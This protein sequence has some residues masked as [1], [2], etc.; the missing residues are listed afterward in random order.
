MIAISYRREDSTPVAGRL[1]DRL[2]AEFGKEN[3]FMDFDSIPYGVDFR[4]HI[5]RTL[6]RADVVVAVIG[7]GW[8]GGQQEAARRI[9]DPSDF[10]RLEIAGALQR[11][12]PVIPILVDDTPM[13]KADAL[14]PEIAAFAF[15]NA[16]VL[17]TGIDFHHHADRLVAGIRDLLKDIPVAPPVKPDTSE[18][19]GP[20]EAPP[21]T[22]SPEAERDLAEKTKW[23]GVLGKLKFPSPTAKPEEHETPTQKAER[24]AVESETAAPRKSS[25]EEPAMKPKRASRPR[26]QGAT[27]AALVQRQKRSSASS[28]TASAATDGAKERK[29]VLNGKLIGLFAGG[30]VVVVAMYLVASSVFSP[31]KRSTSNVAETT[32]QPS[33]TIAPQPSITPAPVVAATAAPSATPAEN[34]VVPNTPAPAL[35]PIAS[36]A[37]EPIYQGATPFASQVQDEEN[38]RQLIREY[39]A[40]LSRHDLDAVVSKFGDNVDY[41]GQG[42]HDKR[43]IRID[44]GNYLRRWDRIAFEPG[45]IHVTR[46]PEGDFVATFNFPFAVGQGRAPDK[47]GIS[48]SV[49]VLRKDLQGNVQIVSQ[50]EK[51]LAGRSK[52]RQSRY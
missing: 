39:Y 37:T 1:H 19:V 32:P 33:A 44:T 41:Q 45:D 29:F 36:A 16:L 24:P 14:P 9:D 26:K 15:R 6:E 7:P 47:R 5:K 21:K 2:R 22:P 10:V 25:A 34:I 3:V 49:W 35:S 52:Q 31:H 13:P 42:H 43:Y 20:K 38:V 50:R 4:E 18:V 12:I 27:P 46:T 28:S 23:P 17:D 48:S 40:A 51:V 8:L 11:G 30:A